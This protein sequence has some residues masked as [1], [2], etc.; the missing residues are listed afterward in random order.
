L[1]LPDRDCVT[2]GASKV[3][4]GEAVPIRLPCTIGGGST[5]PRLLATKEVDDVHAIVA[6]G[7]AV[8]YAPY[9]TD[10]V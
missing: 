5:P 8:E 10:A 1:A 2:T 6:T 3:K 9:A 7:S 4:N